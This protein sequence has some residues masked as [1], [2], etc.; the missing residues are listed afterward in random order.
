MRNE[1]L[2]AFVGLTMCAGAAT[3]APITGGVAAFTLE[4]GGNIG[5]NDG[6]IAS[7]FPG[8]ADVGP[9]GI[10]IPDVPPVPL[11]FPSPGDPRDRPTIASFEVVGGTVD[12]RGALVELDGLETDVKLFTGAGSLLFGNLVVDTEARTV[13]GDVLPGEATHVRRPELLP[14]PGGAARDLPIFDLG[15]G[16]SRGTPVSLTPEFAG[17]LTEVLGLPDETGTAFATLDFAIE[18]AG[19]AASGPAPVPVPAAL[20]LLACGLAALGFTARRRTA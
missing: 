20:P 17:T 3:A 8:A 19:T 15:D 9:L 18:T 7:I 10:E 1:V 6:E 14:D 2:A 12:E 4:P 13:F 5:L 11:G 16:G